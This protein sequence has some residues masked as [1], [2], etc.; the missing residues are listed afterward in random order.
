LANA[1]FHCQQMLVSTRVGGGERL[2]LQI[3]SF[4]NTRRNGSSTLLVPGGGE[5]ERY[6]RSNHLPYRG[7]SLE[8][9]TSRNRF[10]SLSE[11]LRLMWSFRGEGRHS[12]LHVH[13]PYVYGAMRIALAGSRI[14]T[15]LHLHLD[16]SE[17]E[18]A[19]PLRRPPDLIIPCARFM[20]ERVERVL[21]RTSA[22][23]T[24]VAVVVNGVD[25]SRFLPGHRPTARSELGIPVDRP[26][27]LMVAN[28]S[29]HKGQKTA[30]R[31]VGRLRTRGFNPLLWIVG[32]DRESSGYAETLQQLTREL[33]LQGHVEFLGYREDV[34]HLLRAADVLLLPSVREGLPLSIL[35]AQ[36]SKVVVL[37]APTA[38]IPEVIEHG[39][40]GFLIEAADDLAYAETLEKLLLS[41]QLA[42]EVAEVAYRQAVATA[43]IGS[44]C[45]NIAAAYSL[46]G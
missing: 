17:E 35:E 37:A 1:D 46:L 26:V 4:L 10:V 29:E 31:A 23:K 6:A 27:F 7:Y 32:E 33:E 36:V 11:N 12:I 41:P 5:T 34:P 25:T 43:D 38:G 30:I 14:R 40:T 42:A 3:N 19:W 16:Y 13:S 24:R 28:L 22:P 2:A 45:R 15:V 8:R 18:L 21:S 9:L 39:R 44:Y 20:R